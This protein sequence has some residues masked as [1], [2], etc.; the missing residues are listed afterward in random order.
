METVCAGEDD[1]GMFCR[2]GADEVCEDGKLKIAVSLSRNRIN[3]GKK[4]C[5]ALEW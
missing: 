5:A 3:P 4:N 2:R 1:D